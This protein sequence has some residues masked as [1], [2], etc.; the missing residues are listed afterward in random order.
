VRGRINIYAPVV[1]A[2]TIDLSSA[3]TPLALRT[4]PGVA[5]IIARLQD[6]A[7]RILEEN[8]MVYDVQITVDI[9]TETEEETP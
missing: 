4:E 2:L 3:T 9:A 6:A 1:D 5:E 8:A 7:Q